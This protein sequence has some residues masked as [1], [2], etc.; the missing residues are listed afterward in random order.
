[1]DIIIVCHTE[2]GFVSPKK[3]IIYDKNFIP[4]VK[5]GVLNLLKLADKHNAKISFALCPETAPYFPKKINHEIGLHIHPGWQEVS[6]NGFK[7]FS[8]D[9]YLREKCK[10]TINSNFLKDF[11]YSEQLEM[12]RNGKECLFSKFSKE[13]K[14]FVPGRW[15]FNN[16]TA[17]ALVDAGFNCVPSIFVGSKTDYSSH[18]HPRIRLPYFPD[19]ENLQKRGS[20]PILFVPV[21]MTIFGGAAS[22]EGAILYGFGWLKACFLEYFNQ[23][24]P[25]FH[26]Y[27]HS[28]SMTDPYYTSIMD[29]FLTFV[30]KKKDVNFKFVSE[31]KEYP[32][33]KVR[34]NIWP[35]IVRINKQLL[36]TFLNKYLIL[37]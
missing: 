8:G 5:D 25:L 11:S 28:P 26:L 19:K 7:W 16:D 15:S 30:S 32:E 20:M 37:R 24:V 18:N 29:N 12:I 17:K 36:K 1:M 14:F 4:G 23:G 31:I 9:R 10:P 27:L 21:S 33:I 2:F 22:P 35:Y 34:T 3:H 13:P 6:F